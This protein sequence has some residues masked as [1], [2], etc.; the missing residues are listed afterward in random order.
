MLYLAIFCLGVS[1]VL[2]ALSRIDLNARLRALENHDHLHP[3]MLGPTGG[4]L[5]TGQ[6]ILVERN[7][8]TQS[9]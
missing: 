8:D 4:M 1:S 9:N 2:S 6:A 3:T 7:E 5:R